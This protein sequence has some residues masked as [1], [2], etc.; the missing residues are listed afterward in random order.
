MNDFYVLVDNNKKLIL[1]PASFLPEDWMN[2]HGIKFLPY[3][4]LV[5]LSWAGHQ[6]RGMLK[7]TD[8]SLHSYEYNSDWINFT[9][10]A[11][12]DYV[13]KQRKEREE[14]I[15]I[16][17]DNFLV[18]IDEK[19]KLA[20]SAKRVFAVEDSS[21]TCIWKFENTSVELTA[22]DIISLSDSINKYIQDCFDAEYNFA[23]S[24]NA[25]TSIEEFSTLS[26]NVTWPSTDL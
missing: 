16:F 10:S 24:V 7:L 6:D 26:L 18:R 3:E 12:T 1:A 17:N 11:I 14:Q 20:L 15:V 23:Q 19:T 13:S 9:R 21:Y 2:V 5:D 25:I 8:E 22:T 4:K